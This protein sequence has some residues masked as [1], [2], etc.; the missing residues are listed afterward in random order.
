[1]GFFEHRRLKKG[2][3]SADAATRAETAAALATTN[4]K[5]ADSMLIALLSDGDQ[6]VREKA[7]ASLMQRASRRYGDGTVKALVTAPRSITARILPKLAE[8]FLDRL[9]QPRISVSSA[10]E[11]SDAIR[12]LGL[13][14][15]RR[16]IGP[17]L[18]VIASGDMLDQRH[19]ANALGDVGSEFPHDIIP[20]IDAFLMSVEPKKPWPKEGPMP[21]LPQQDWEFAMQALSAAIGPK[22]AMVRLMAASVARMNAGRK[23]LMMFERP[24]SS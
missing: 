18:H 11:W 24:A 15:D 8:H 10:L 20:A 9:K 13:L 16:A 7:A 21:V 1:M 4:D 14:K 6:A 3:S 17:L 2:V 23:P 22:D 5:D 12:S 19:A